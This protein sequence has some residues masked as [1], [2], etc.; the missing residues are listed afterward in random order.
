MRKHHKITALLGL[1]LLSIFALSACGEDA[2]SKTKQAFSEWNGVSNLNRLTVWK[3]NEDNSPDPEYWSK[4][5]GFTLCYKGKETGSRYKLAKDNPDTRFVS[6]L[7]R[8]NNTLEQL[9]ATKCPDSLK[10]SPKP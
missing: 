7:Y 9:Y 2:P 4:E 6:V 8:G 10:S 5:Q 3:D 1:S